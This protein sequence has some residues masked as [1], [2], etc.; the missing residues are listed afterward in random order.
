[1]LA[2]PKIFRGQAVYE[3]PILQKPTFAAQQEIGKVGLISAIRCGRPPKQRSSLK[4]KGRLC[5]TL[6]PFAAIVE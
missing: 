2:N 3:H 4:V 1:M 5:G 6:L